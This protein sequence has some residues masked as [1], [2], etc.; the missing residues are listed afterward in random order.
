[1]GM[2][3]DPA[4]GLTGK[5]RSERPNPSTTRTPGLVGESGG[6]ESMASSEAGP[7]AD[8]LTD[9]L[10][11]DTSAAPEAGNA[12]APAEKPRVPVWAWV[13]IGLLAAAVLAVSIGLLFKVEDNPATARA[14][15]A[16][17]LELMDSLVSDVAVTNQ[18]VAGLNTQ[19][20]SIMSAAESAASSAQSKASRKKA[21][22]S[23]KEPSRGGG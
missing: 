23:S 3:A 16:S 12:S 10:R 6:R 9:V 17:S 15:A 5:L 4:R 14:A 2:P 1:M 21:Q 20:E 22:A 19:L 8:D 7:D 18:Q 11:T 13:V